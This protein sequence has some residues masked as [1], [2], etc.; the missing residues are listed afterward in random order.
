MQT[1]AT[2]KS[3]VS[4][5]LPDG[6]LSRT[7]ASFFFFLSSSLR[8]R[9]WSFPGID[10]RFAFWRGAELRS[11]QLAKEKTL[12][13]RAFQNLRHDLINA[14]AQVGRSVPRRG[15]SRYSFFEKGPRWDVSIV[16]LRLKHDMDQ[17][18]EEPQDTVSRTSQLSDTSTVSRETRI[19]HS[20]NSTEFLP[21]IL[22]LGPSRA[23][24]RRRADSDS[25]FF[26][27]FFP[28]SIS[29]SCPS[30]L[31]RFGK[32]E[33]GYLWKKIHRDL[34]ERVGALDLSPLPRRSSPVL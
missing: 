19:S 3:S 9:E 26:S 15:L 18:S 24:R 5:V 29:V 34:C 4:D 13:S 7:K 2:G 12:L 17:S 10:L 11:A 14:V 31:R 30:S 28:R 27:S 6:P 20:Q 8:E 16:S 32:R 21:S 22:F 23:L 25:R 33:M 1:I